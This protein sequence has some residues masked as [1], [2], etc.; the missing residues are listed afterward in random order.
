LK[1]RDKNASSYQ[2]KE[3]ERVNQELQE[4][5]QPYLLQRDK[6][7]HLKDTLTAKLLQIAVMVHRSPEQERCYKEICSGSLVQAIISGETPSPLVAITELRKVCGHPLL[8]R[9]RREKDAE[10]GADEAPDD[11]AQATV[12]RILRDGPKLR[13]TLDLV[14]KF[15]GEGSRTL[16]FSER[17]TVL[18]FIERVFPVSVNFLRIDGSTPTGRRQAIVDAF[19][20]NERYDVMLIST[21]AGGLGL[22]I[23]GA[24]R[25]IGTSK[26]RVRVLRYRCIVF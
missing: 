21:R 5:I 18:D 10:E 9:K 4:I 22:T 15:I 19:N 17:T 8:S 6:K 26:T 23:T 14:Q 1:S 24:N 13:V 25:V 11:L 16:I 20:S 12:A 2:I 7:T 3:G